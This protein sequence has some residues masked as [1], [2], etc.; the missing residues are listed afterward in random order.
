MRYKIKKRI[1]SVFFLMVAVLFG[2]FLGI[3]WD[4]I[5]RSKMIN[6][7]DDTRDYTITL[8]LKDTNL[9]TVNRMDEIEDLVKKSMSNLLVDLMAPPPV[10]EIFKKINDETIGEKAKILKELLDRIKEKEK[11]KKETE[12]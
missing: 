12:I 7:Y 9:L 10:K 6:V 1:K 2:W 3:I 5:V 11:K 8:S 4:P